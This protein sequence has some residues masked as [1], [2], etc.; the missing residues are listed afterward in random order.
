MDYLDWM[1][2]RYQTLLYYA[3]YYDTFCTKKYELCIFVYE[4]IKYYSLEC[5]IP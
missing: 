3:I 1:S 4:K 5:Q 2:N